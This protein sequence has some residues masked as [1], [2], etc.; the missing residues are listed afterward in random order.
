M[1]ERSGRRRIDMKDCCGGVIYTTKQRHIEFKH[2]QDSLQVLQDV[3][4]EL[5]SGLLC[6]RNHH[7]QL[8]E[9]VDVD[10]DG[11]ALSS[12]PLVTCVGRN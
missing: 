11:A 1:E 8:L 3:C 4:C 6:V 9:R 12:L 7:I 2:L 10:R 5:F